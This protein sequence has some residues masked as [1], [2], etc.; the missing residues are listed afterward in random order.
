MTNPHRGEID[1]KVGDRAYLLRLGANE[2]VE[3]ES[4]LGMVVSEI[5]EALQKPE[6]V[7]MGI[8]R[9]LLFAALHE[10]Q[11]DMTLRD[12]GD[13]IGEIGMSEAVSKVG[14]AIQAGFPRAD[15]KPRPRKASPPRG[16][17]K[18]S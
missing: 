2:V 15:G 18:N 14:D 12:A 10:N 16:T 5:F 9:G 3:A 4:V 8:V 13:L 7:S 6:T 1:L 17:G 11:P